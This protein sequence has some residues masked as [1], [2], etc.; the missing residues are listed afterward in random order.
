MIGAWPVSISGR[1]PTLAEVAD[2]A[3]RA[4]LGGQ[5]GSV[6]S[7]G[8]RQ[9]TVEGQRYTAVVRP[10]ELQPGVR[11]MV[12]VYAPESDFSLGTQ[13]ADD[14]RLTTILLAGLLGSLLAWPLLARAVRP[15]KALQHQA[16]TDPLTGLRNRA[17]FLAQLDEALSTPQGS[18]VPERHLGVA[19]VDLDGF[20]RINDTYGHAAGDEVLLAVGGRMLAAMRPGDTLG[21]LGGDEFALLAQG[22]SREEVRLRVEGVLAALVRRPV[23]VGAQ[24]HGVQATAGLAFH[25]PTEP[26]TEP[27]PRTTLL[28]RADAALIAG[29]RREKGRVWADGESTMSNLFS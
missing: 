23:L 22:A 24:E 2:P 17:S 21:R 1:V 11:W 12:G 19:I 27:H 15:M 4:L 16:T 3:L 26:L 25:D 18:D 29:K 8:N 6:L 20:K 13:R 10:V 9:Y 5:G 7:P 14:L 28:A